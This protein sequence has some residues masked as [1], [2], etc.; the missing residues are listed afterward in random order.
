ML[1]HDVCFLPVSQVMGHNE[2]WILKVQEFLKAHLHDLFSWVPQYDRILLE[3]AANHASCSN[4]AII[5]YESVGQYCTIDTNKYIVPYDYFSEYIGIA[6]LI[7]ET[8]YGAIV[9]D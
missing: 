1:F 8:L 2:T 9:S 4:N 3:L 7:P 5:T 6:Y